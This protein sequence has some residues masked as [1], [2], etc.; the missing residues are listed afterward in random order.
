MVLSCEEIG[1]S[2]VIVTR[3][4]GGEF[5]LLVLHYLFNPRSLHGVI[6]IVRHARREW[7][8]R[9]LLSP[10]REVQGT[11]DFIRLRCQCLSGIIKSA[12][13]D[14]ALSYDQMFVWAG[15]ARSVREYSGD[16]K[17]CIND[18]YG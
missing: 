12:A 15:P 18:F 1:I 5:C 13:D 3:Y 2:L 16:I 14:A 9:L 10:H 11:Q 8:C 6:S 17:L 7:V 4:T